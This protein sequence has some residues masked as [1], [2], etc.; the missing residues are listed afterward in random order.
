[1]Q[2]Y[3]SYAKLRITNGGIRIA[4]ILKKRHNQD[5]T[6]QDSIFLHDGAY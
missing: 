6:S 4:L 2:S 5:L 1:M 3:E